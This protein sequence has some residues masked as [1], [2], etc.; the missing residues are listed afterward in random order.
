MVSKINNFVIGFLD[1]AHLDT[2]KI[3]TTYIY[4]LIL[5]PLFFGSFITFAL[6]I[7]NQNINVVLNNTPL[8]A[9]DMIVALTD[10]IMGYYIW[11]KKDLILKHEGNYRFLMF[12]QAI[13]QLMVGNIF[14]LILAFFGIIRINEQSDKLKCQNNFIKLPSFIFLTIFGFCLVLTISIFIRK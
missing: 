3:L 7:A 8:I 14:C 11:L 4:A 6:S 10:F 13:S 5:I 2:K 9:I 1:R 12:S